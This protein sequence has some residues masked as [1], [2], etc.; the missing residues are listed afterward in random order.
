MLSIYFLENIILEN[1]MIRI[2]ENNKPSRIF[3]II[4]KLFRQRRKYSIPPMINK[5][6][7]TFTVTLNKTVR[8]VLVLVKRLI[9]LKVFSF[10]AFSVGK[11]EIFHLSC[12]HK[13]SQTNYAVGNIT[14]PYEMCGPM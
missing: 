14:H 12:F 3:P 7:Y 1:N 11:N 9:T 6:L 13:K 2:Y 5:L 4:K 10:S 8:I